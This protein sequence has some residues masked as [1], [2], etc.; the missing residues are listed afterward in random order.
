MCAL[1]RRFA[2]LEPTPL[3]EPVV[4]SDVESLVPADDPSRRSHSILLNR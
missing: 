3:P 2:G 1:Y 4:V